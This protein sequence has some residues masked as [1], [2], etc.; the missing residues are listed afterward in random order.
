MPPS[1]DFPWQI[2][3]KF[4]TQGVVHGHMSRVENDASLGMK[5]CRKRRAERVEDA[6]SPKR[7]KLVVGETATGKTVYEDSSS[8]SSS[9]SPSSSDEEVIVNEP[10]KQVKAAMSKNHRRCA[11]ATGSG[12]QKT[13]A[14]DA[15]DAGSSEAGSY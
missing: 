10:A 2:A 12:P 8:H 4:I 15:T 5:Q 1:Y 9:S 13:D 14:T 11:Y 6:D 7:A 3:T